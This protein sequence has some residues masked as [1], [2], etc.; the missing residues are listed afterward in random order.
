MA[1]QEGQYLADLFRHYAFR[2]H[3]MPDGTITGPGQL[4]AVSRANLEVVRNLRRL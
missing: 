3:T 2:V 1:H 4:H